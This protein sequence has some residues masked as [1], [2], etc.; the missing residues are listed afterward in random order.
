MTVWECS[1]FS[2]LNRQAVGCDVGK[3]VSPLCV[4][5][6]A[7]GACSR[8]LLTCL[9]YAAT[10]SLGFAQIGGKTSA[11]GRFVLEDA[12]DLNLTAVGVQRD[13]IWSNVAGSTQPF[14][15]TAIQGSGLTPATGQSPNGMIHFSVPASH[16]YVDAS[17]GVPMPSQPGQS[18]EPYPGNLTSFETMTFLTCFDP[19]MTDQRFEI[20]LECYPL[21]GAT[22]PKLYWSYTPTAGTTFQKV[23]IALHSPYLVENAGGRSVEQ[24]LSQA[25]Y[26]SFYYYGA[27]ASKATLDACVDDIGFES[28][29]AVHDWQL[30]H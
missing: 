7:N 8:L 11:D 15:V 20:I 26:M 27:S 21:V 17:F 18:T 2:C 29:A 4:V 16:G 22:Y 14:T 12:E 5:R 9:I 19:V 13:W 23:S 6:K 25:R 3:P 30:F 10:F 24:L 1:A 28:K